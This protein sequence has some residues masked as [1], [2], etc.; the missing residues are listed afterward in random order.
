MQPADTSVP[1]SS[2]GDPLWEIATLFAPQ[3][4]WDEV[5]YLSLPTN[6]LVEYCDGRLEFLP[7]PTELHQLIVKFL[8]GQLD[9]WI[10]RGNPGLAL[11]APMRIRMSSGRFREPDVVFMRDD[12][13]DRRHQQFWDGADLVMEVVSEDDPDR[14]LVTKRA[15]YAAAGIPE[16]WI[17]DPRDQSVTVLTHSQLNDQPN[18]YEESGK[19]QNGEV[20]RSST[21]DGLRVDLDQ[22]FGRQ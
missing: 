6:R 3:G 18:T 10:A 21:C 1:Q 12:H 20:V 17:V 15:E 5:E 11:F 19:Y 16:Y 14:D 7:M 8:C 4:L 2:K 13:A 22:I 9:A